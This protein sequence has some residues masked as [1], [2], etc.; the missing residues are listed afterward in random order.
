MTKEKI[1]WDEIGKVNILDFC[2]QNGIEYKGRGDSFQLT[3][4]D[5]CHITPSKNL[6]HWFS[7]GK[8]GSILEFV[9][10]V[11]DLGEAPGWRSEAAGMV[12]DVTGVQKHVY[13]AEPKKPAGPYKYNQKLEDAQT[14]KAER[15]LEK[16]RGISPKIVDYFIRKGLI[17]QDTHGNALFLWRDKEKKIVGCSRQGTSEIFEGER[18]WKKIDFNSRQYYGFNVTFRRKDEIPSDLYVFEANID[19]MSYLTEKPETAH[20]ATFMSMDGLKAETV[21]KFM[22]EQLDTYGKGFSKIHMC[23]D[24]DE[25]GNKFL[26]DIAEGKHETPDGDTYEVVYDQPSKTSEDDHKSDWNSHLQHKIGADRY[27]YPANLEN[28]NTDYLQNHLLN[29]G[30]DLKV[31]QYM[32]QNGL[33]RQDRYKRAVFPRFNEQG[34]IAGHSVYNTFSKQL[35]PSKMSEQEYKEQLE[36][37]MTRQNTEHTAKNSDMTRPFKMKFGTPQ[38]IYIFSNAMD[39]PAYLSVK[40]KMT[41]KEKKYAKNAVFMSLTG[42]S[43]NLA[44]HR[45]IV[46]TFREALEKQM[47]AGIQNPKLNIHVCLE[48]SQKSLKMMQQA[49]SIYEE[50]SWQEERDG[51]TVTISTIHDMPPK[52]DGKAMSWTRYAEQFRN[53]P[54]EMPRQEVKIKAELKEIIKRKIESS[55]Y[56]QKNLPNAWISEADRLSKLD[57]I[58][59]LTP[60]AEGF[61]ERHRQ[62]IE[63]IMKLNLKNG[64]GGETRWN[65]LVTARE[66]AQKEACMKDVCTRAVKVAAENLKTQLVFRKKEL[67]ENGGLQQQQTD[68]LKA[69]EGKKT[70]REQF[71]AGPKKAP[72][73]SSPDDGL[74]IA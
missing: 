22:G 61:F 66:P 64:S 11:Y 37:Q 31:A 68:S 54:E 38:D 62:E 26:A 9:R 27:S 8:G 24:N 49:T 19:L 59:R 23:V 65:R 16:Q 36:K 15:Y 69:D 45:E 51:R 4:H 58:D 6:F 44:D 1:N 20:N 10:E 17:R 41:G 52:N 21:A 25:G 39:I 50:H 30:I 70:D 74:D 55:P 7:R 29:K 67:E 73:F 60:D 32:L 57:R 33:V 47:E 14:Y 63:N 3:D 5:S 12:A 72:K 18:S 53:T 28:R 48:N 46:R 2:D 13:V 35:D 56:R 42:N 43:K 34:E 40:P 71:D